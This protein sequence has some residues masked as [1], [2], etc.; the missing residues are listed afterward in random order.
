[1]EA[2]A[3]TKIG[4]TLPDPPITFKELFAL[5]VT[6]S[7]YICRGLDFRSELLDLPLF[8]S[9]NLATMFSQSMELL[10]IS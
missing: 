8:I 3:F 2:C 7:M 1:M 9:F 6:V 4:P 5:F 10:A